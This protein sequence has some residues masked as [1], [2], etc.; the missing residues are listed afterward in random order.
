MWV[1]RP[2]VSPLWRDGAPHQCMTHH[3]A[4]SLC[5]ITILLEGC[6]I[7]GG[8][9]HPVSALLRRSHSAFIQ[10]LLTCVVHA[11][12]ITF[13]LIRPKILCLQRTRPRVSRSLGVSGL[14]WSATAPPVGVLGQSNWL[15]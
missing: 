10:C 5:L 11:D 4:S 15:P 9:E 3:Y 6:S 13:H 8:T 14:R 7:L 1:L 12:A 2:P